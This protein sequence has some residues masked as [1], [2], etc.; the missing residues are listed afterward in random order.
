MNEQAPISPVRD[1]AIQA[2]IDA[3]HLRMLKIVYYVAGVLTAVTSCFLIFHFAMFLF[4]GLS[5]EFFAAHNSSGDRQPGPPAAFFLVIAGLIGFIMLLGW[6]FGALQI[7]AGRCLERRQRITFVT[8]IAALE[9]IFIPWGT[10]IGV[11][12]F[13]VLSRDSV[14]LLFNPSFYA[15][16]QS[17]GKT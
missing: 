6:T 5:P 17:A 15:P 16:P 7:Y 11:F 4:L 3:E 2:A 13:L 10:V 14:R 12:T 8:I 1:P 9:C